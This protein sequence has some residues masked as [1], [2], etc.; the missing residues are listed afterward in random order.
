[1][2]FAGLAVALV[3]NVA[4]ADARSETLTA[5]VDA[6]RSGLDCPDRDE[7]LQRFHRAEMLF[8]QL[9]EGA[10]DEN[11]PVPAIRNPDLFVNWG[12]AALCAQ[13]VGTA[14]LAY[15]RALEID[16]D[17]R[18]AQQN[19]RH[20]RAQLPEWVPRREEG[21]LLDTFFSWSAR[22]SRGERES[23]AAVLFLLVTVLMAAS[24]RWRRTLFR[25]LA[26]LPAAVWFALLAT[27][28]WDARQE[29]GREA[30]IA[31]SEVVAR[32]ADSIHAP[33]RFTQPLPSGTEVEVVE[34]RDDW[35]QIRLADDRDAWVPRT[36][37]AMIK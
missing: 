29:T 34:K 25:N 8:A 5:A 23:A 2:L 20:A 35:C 10:P 16:P 26:L 6:Y 37:L 1:L 27:L 14:V 7:R 24:I 30:V 11:P 28:I 17:H 19:L 15:R 36:A 31:A 18:R 13:H 33:S 4:S 12:N 9:V 21:G 22:L 3:A 32:S